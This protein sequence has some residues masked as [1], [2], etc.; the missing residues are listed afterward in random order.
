[1]WCEQWHRSLSF[2]KYLQGEMFDCRTLN[3]G[4]KVKCILQ[5]KKQKQKQISSDA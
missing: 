4:L 2:M 3:D 1:M 5:K